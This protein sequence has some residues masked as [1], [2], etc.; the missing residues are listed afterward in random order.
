MALAKPRQISFDP[1][2][3][4]DRGSKSEQPL[5]LA[6]I[7]DQR[8]NVAGPG[9]RKFNGEVV[10]AALPDDGFGHLAYGDETPAAQVDCLAD[11]GFARASAPEALGGIGDVSE[12]PSLPA[13]AEHNGRIPA[14]DPDCEPR[15]HLG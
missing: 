6:R 13:V 10:A 15:N 8:L 1:A 4:I 3:E 2:R 9:R 11:N 14:E 7:G 12:I 5:R